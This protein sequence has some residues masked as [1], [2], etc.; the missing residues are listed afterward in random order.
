MPSAIFFV[1][2]QRPS[3]SKSASVGGNPLGLALIPRVDQRDDIFHA[4]KFV[5]RASGHR[6]SNFQRLMDA[7][8][9]VEHEIERQ[10]VAVVLKLL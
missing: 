2:P 7:A 1:L 6:G 3:I 9:I 4:P 5:S 8:E 10:R